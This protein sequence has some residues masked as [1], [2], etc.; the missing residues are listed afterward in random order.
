MRKQLIGLGLAGALSLGLGWATA[1]HADDDMPSEATK[2]AGDEAQRATDSADQAGKNAATGADESAKSA[3][4]EA[5]RAAN[6]AAET[7]KRS[8]QAA[9][10]AA[11]DTSD[12]ARG[13]TDKARGAMPPSE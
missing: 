3:G 10:K 12:R 11:K 6:G 4:D 5:D 1:A 9:D 7:G 8:G 2:S 13:A